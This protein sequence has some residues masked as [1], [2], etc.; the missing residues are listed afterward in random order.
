MV[1]RKHRSRYV[2]K[3][4]QDLEAMGRMLGAS[5]LTGRRSQNIPGK[6]KKHHIGRRAGITVQCQSRLYPPVSD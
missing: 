1:G 5:G 2:R 4:A 3:D 6:F